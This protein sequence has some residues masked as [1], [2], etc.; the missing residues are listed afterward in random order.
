MDAL[1]I[2]SYIALRVS[3]TLAPGPFVAILMARA[4]SNDARG[5]LAF[6]A[7]KAIGDIAMIA[8]IC[9]GLAGWLQS[10]PLALSGAKLFAVA[11]LLW[12][13]VSIWQNGAGLNKT[14]QSHDST[15]T[16][17]SAG[18]LTCI[19]SPQTLLIYILLLPSLIDTATI[20]TT[21]FAII[22][23]TTLAALCASFAIVICLASRLRDCLIG[24][25]CGTVINRTLALVVGASGVWMVTA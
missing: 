1:D 12:I 19:M 9:N 25:S 13:S 23:A 7:G 2:S 15:I 4:L 3:M 17:A 16:S 24:A 10:M 6:G 5:A 8:L 21:T 18:F 11:Y 14:S 20:D 22:S